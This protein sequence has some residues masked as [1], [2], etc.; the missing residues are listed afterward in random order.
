MNLYKFFEE[1][2]SLQIL[3]L[4]HSTFCFSITGRMSSS[5]DD[6]DDDTSSYSP[7]A[8][9]S[10]TPPTASLTD[11]ESFDYNSDHYF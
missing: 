2:I 4:L 8:G 1:Q 5:Q 9:K 7:S 3:C 6:L 11:D 10:M